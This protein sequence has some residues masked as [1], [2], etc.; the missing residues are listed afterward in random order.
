MFVDTLF[1]LPC[2]EPKVKTSPMTYFC[3]SPKTLMGKVANFLKLFLNMRMEGWGLLLFQSDYVVVGRGP[4]WSNLSKF[5]KG[6][7][8]REQ[9]EAKM[10]D[11]NRRLVMHVARNF[12]VVFLLKHLSLG[13]I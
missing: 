4:K 9:Q 5:H 1:R 6:G 8:C 12:L 7:P 2:T 11:Q 3:D 10:T 13:E